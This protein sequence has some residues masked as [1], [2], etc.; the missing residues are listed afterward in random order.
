MTN[1][2]NDQDQQIIE[3]EIIENQNETIKEKKYKRKPKYYC[4]QC[5]YLTDRISNFNTHLI[6]NRHKKKSKIVTINTDSEKNI[7]S[8]D[9]CK[10]EFDSMIDL[11]NHKSTCTKKI[12]RCKGCNKE[13]NHPSSYYSHMNVCNQ[14]NYIKMDINIFSKLVKNLLLLDDKN[15]Y[16]I[17]D[18][19]NDDKKRQ[20]IESLIKESIAQPI[21]PPPIINST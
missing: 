9:K 12:Y 17:D 14:K 5:S 3:N 2:T 20:Y 16:S 11:S 6:S 7:Y 21:Q 15:N 18:L 1:E 4:E 10:C 19:M 13:Y 8:C